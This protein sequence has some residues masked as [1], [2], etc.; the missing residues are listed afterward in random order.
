MRLSSSGSIQA[1]FAGVAITL[2]IG[3]NSMSLAW[4][5]SQGLAIRSGPGQSLAAIE[6]RYAV[7]GNGRRPSQIPCPLDGPPHGGRLRVDDATRWSIGYV[8]FVEGFRGDLNGTAL[9]A[10]EGRRVA[11]AIARL[12]ELMRKP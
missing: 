12:P 2:G 9:I 3:A 11:D 1:Q 5:Y 7:M 4:S 10:E 8:Y 6:S